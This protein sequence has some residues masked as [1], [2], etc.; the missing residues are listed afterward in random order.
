MRI[1]FYLEYRGPGY[2]HP[3]MP[4]VFERLEAKGCKV[5]W[6]FPEEHVFSQAEFA[7]EYDL[8][9]LKSSSPMTYQLGAMISTKG[10]RMINDFRA[11]Q[12]I[13]N[14]VEINKLLADN[15]V[16]IPDSFLTGDVNLL[17]EVVAAKGP[18]IVKPY[19]GR[20]GI[21]VEIVRT[22][23]ELDRIDVGA[24]VYAQLFKQGDGYDRKTYM[25]GDRAYASKKAFAAGQS[26]LKDAIAMEITPE[27]RSI[28]LKCG[29]VVGLQVYGVDMIE[30]EDG[31][32]VI[33]V[34]GFP[35]FKGL[36][37]IDEVLAE[38]VYD[39]AKAGA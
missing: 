27:M 18:L 3:V 11:I 1:C 12:R 4:K 37:G 24:E 2:V 7:I 38:Y 20:H 13:K 25:V 29:Q 26:F 14:K 39:Y 9:V 8:Y 22:P 10:G 17:K 35:G 33:D 5:D 28:A 30:A 16:P 34:N 19:D 15:G 23:E 32:W 21:G 6:L 31:L 36:P